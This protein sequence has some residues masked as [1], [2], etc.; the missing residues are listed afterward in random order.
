MRTA[1]LGMVSP[2][3]RGSELFLLRRPLNLTNEAMLDMELRI[4]LRVNEPGGREGEGGWEGG[5]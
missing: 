3:F 5:R 2:P 4:E 1:E